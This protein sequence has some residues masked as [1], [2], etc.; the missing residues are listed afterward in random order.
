MG[1]YI[2]G[3]RVRGNEGDLPADSYIIMLDEVPLVMGTIAIGQFYCPLPPAQ[4]LAWGVPESDVTAYAQPGGLPGCWVKARQAVLSSAV[5]RS[6][7]CITV[8]GDTSTSDTLLLFA[9]GARRH[10]PIVVP[11]VP[12]LEDFRAKLD[13]VTLDLAHQVVRDGEGA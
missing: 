3:I 6:F 13:E 8:D 7:N 12:R 1:V 4:L 10:G 5:D 9:T 2:P 11:G